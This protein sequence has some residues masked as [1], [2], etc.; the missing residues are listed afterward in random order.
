MGGIIMKSVKVNI[1]SIEKVKSLVNIVAQ[2]EYDVDLISGRYII[3][4]KSIM[5]VFSLDL[6]EPIE[7]IIHSDSDCKDI[8]SLL[9]PFIVK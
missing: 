5:G 9:E 8:L 7:L 1:N 3:D 4:A 2:F 6:S